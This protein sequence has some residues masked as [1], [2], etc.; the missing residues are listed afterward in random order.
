MNRKPL[1]SFKAVFFFFLSVGVFHLPL[2]KND[3]VSNPDLDYGVV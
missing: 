2:L 1:E 3:F